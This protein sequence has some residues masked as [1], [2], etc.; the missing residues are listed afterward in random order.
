ME[1]RLA[2]TIFGRT[3][4]SICRWIDMGCE[5]KRGRENI[6]PKG[7]CLSNWEDRVVFS[8]TKPAEKQPTEV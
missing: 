8:E 4:G 5:R 1:K 2:L 6:D 7:F 3:A